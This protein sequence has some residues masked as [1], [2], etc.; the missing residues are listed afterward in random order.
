MGMRLPTRGTRANSPQSNREFPVLESLVSMLRCGNISTVKP[1]A[2][3]K[4]PRDDSL[5]MSRA[6][7]TQFRQSALKVAYGYAGSS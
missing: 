4:R 6:H 1:D 5:C 7:L 3:T 2:I